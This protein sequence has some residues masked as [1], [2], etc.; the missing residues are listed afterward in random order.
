MSDQ[1]YRDAASAINKAGAVPFPVNDTLLDILKILMTPEQAQFVQMLDRPLN[2]GELEKKSGLSGD[3]LDRML[4][5]LMDNGVITGAA[6]R[7][8]G[9]MVYRALPPIPGIFETTMMRGETGEKQKTLARLF[10]KLFEELSAMVQQN[11][12]A[13]VP[14]LKAVPPMTRIVPVEKQVDRSLDTVMPAEDVK[15]LIDR[16]DTI[17]VAYCYCRHQKDLLGRSCRVTDER[18]N[19]LLFGKTAE[20]FIAHQF[21]VPVTRDQARTIMEKAEADGLV[22]KAFHEKYDTGK[23]EMAVCNCCKC[24]C[25]TFNSFYRGGV[26]TITYTAYIARVDA[27]TCTGCESCVEICPMEAIA[28][29]DGVARIDDPRCIGCG[30]CAY[31]CP[32]EA[33]TLERTGQRHVFVPP[34]KL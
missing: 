19:C 14:A 15:K 29:A 7:S 2:R 5:D 17:A 4:N 31:H 13:V 8:A 1:I 22:H 33:L 10:E 20:F 28:M 16:F 6:S 11:Y 32:A 27:G 24:C 34:P 30:V 21:A 23:D 12:D 9:M 18:K 25:E 3:A 26:P